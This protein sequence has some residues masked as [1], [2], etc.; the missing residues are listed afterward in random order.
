LACNVI[1]R[2]RFQLQLH[3]IVIVIDKCV[4]VIGIGPLKLIFSQLQVFSVL[5]MSG[6]LGSTNC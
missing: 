5:Y 6:E 3:I 4:I 1:D 2:L